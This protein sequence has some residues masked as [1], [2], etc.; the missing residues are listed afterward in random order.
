MRTMFT[1]LGALALPFLIGAQIYPLPQSSEIGFCSFV[2]DCVELIEL[3][4]SSQ[5]LW[6]IGLPQKAFFDTAFSPP[7]A[8][9]TDLTEVYPNNN[10]SLF[11]LEVPDTAFF[12]TYNMLLSFKHQYQTDSLRDGGYIEISY[13]GGDTWVNVI[14]DE[15]PVDLEFENI[16]APGDTLF[17]GQ[18]GFTGTSTDWIT[19]KIQWIW[20]L[21]VRSSQDEDPLIR[22]SFVSDDV[23]AGLAGWMID[24]IVLSTGDLGSPTRNPNRL[25]SARIYPNPMSNQAEV[26]IEG[27]EDE[28]QEVQV[29]DLWGRKRQVLRAI[30]R[31]TYR[32]DRGDLLPGLY[33]IAHQS[34]TT[35]Q[36]LGKLWVE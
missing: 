29:L 8:L 24:D 14:E 21:P 12:V 19:T 3:D 20:Q 9:I 10:R 28:A 15:R 26:R 1:L 32:I 33:L 31:E 30:D 35:H 18:P 13:D 22:F 23:G 2:D 7:N 34:A 17:N 11:F 16:Y 4:T 36:I 27:L 5:N 6:T 25:L